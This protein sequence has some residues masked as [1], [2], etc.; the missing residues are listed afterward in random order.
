MIGNLDRDRDQKGDSQTCERGDEVDASMTIKTD[1]TVLGLLQDRAI[2]LSEVHMVVAHARKTG[3]SFKSR[4]TGHHLACERLSNT[5]YWVECR[6]EDDACSI[7]TAYSHRMEILEE[8][9]TAAKSK[10]EKTEWF[11]AK[12]NRDLEPATVKLKYLDEAFAVTLPSCPSCQRVLVSE[13]VALEK[14]ALAEKMLEDK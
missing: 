3:D 5:T 1:S 10:D 2:G 4:V 14:I 8:Y 6:Q 13:K 7:V 11:C 9:N 12:C